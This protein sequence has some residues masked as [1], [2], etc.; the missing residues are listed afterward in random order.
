M[1]SIVLPVFNGEKYLKESIESILN[2]TYTNFELVIVN[3]CSTDNSINIIN[4]YKDKDCRIKVINNIT[5][6]KLPASLNIGFSYCQG[7]YFTWTSDDNI[8][9]NNALEI[10]RRSLIDNNADLVFSRCSV[11]NSCGQEIG[12]TALCKN[13]DDIYINNIVLACFLYKREVHEQLNGYDTNKFLVEDYDFW[14]RA[15]EKF[16]FYYEREILYK[17]RFHAGNLGSSN[18]ELVKLKKIELLKNNINSL[19][20]TDLI[21]SINTEISNCYFYIFFHYLIRIKSPLK[22]IKIFIYFLF[23]FFKSLFIIKR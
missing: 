23:V 5:N 7:K 14:L 21:D 1:I 17:I 18:W 15:Y 12:K 9:N 19:Q 8:F 3:D 4:Y 20:N 16:K 22:K 6:Q 11:I 10:L 2:Q 13:L